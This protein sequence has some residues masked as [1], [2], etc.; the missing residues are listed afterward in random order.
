LK[1][2]ASG[3]ALL[4]LPMILLVGSL[5]LAA[6][7]RVILVGDAWSDPI[8]TR[9]RDELGVLGFEVEIVLGGATSGDLAALARSH[10]AAAAAR[11]DAAA[12]AIDLWVDP[13][14]QPGTIADLR[15]DGPG[16]P[17]LL[18]L[19]AVE[20][21]RGRLLHADLAPPRAAALAAD[22]GDAG[23]AGALPA[24]P[25]PPAA[26]PLVAPQSSSPVAPSR[27]ATGPIALFLAPAALLSPGG[28]P[29]TP[30]VRLGAEWFP[31]DRVGVELVTFLP[32]V[33]ATVSA[34]Q[35]SVALRILELGGGLRGLLTDPT[36][37]LSFGVG[38]GLNAM[39]LMFDGQAAPPFAAARGSRWIASPYASIGAAYRVYPRLALRAEI[40]TT[41]AR[42]EPVIRIAG[43][44]VAVFGQPAV[45]LSLG[46]EVRP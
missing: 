36:A 45:F 37:D 9:L 2:R 10:G 19:R 40:L 38:L 22:G 44:E 11:V 6:G 42:P 4:A 27:R 16:E 35:G 29:T 33:P 28:L 30:H 13:T 21:L 3:V 24:A 46:L 31:A 20:V 7:P 5:V 1:L 25:P 43:R 14:S 41:I 34:A 17:A 15:I 32:T 8:V 26:P 18:A 23:D 12:S 39:L